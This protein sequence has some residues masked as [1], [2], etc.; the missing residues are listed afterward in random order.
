MLRWATCLEAILPHTHTPLLGCTACCSTGTVASDR[1]GKEQVMESQSTTPTLW[2]ATGRM[3][4]GSTLP[5]AYRVLIIRRN[6]RHVNNATYG[7]VCTFFLTREGCRRGRYCNF[8]H[9]GKGGGT[10]LP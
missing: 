4:N 5:V 2:K 3:L 1:S 7:R 6:E 8:L 9:I 10:A